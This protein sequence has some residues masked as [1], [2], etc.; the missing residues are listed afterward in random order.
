MRIEDF[1]GWPGMGTPFYLGVLTRSSV[2][3]RTTAPR[4]AQFDLLIT[5]SS[6]EVDAAKGRVERLARTHEG[7]TELI[8]RAP[9][10]TT[11][12]FLS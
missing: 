1:Q 5:G 11:P 2:S 6:R 7:E 10:A 9:F 12:G 4:D 8:S 3:G